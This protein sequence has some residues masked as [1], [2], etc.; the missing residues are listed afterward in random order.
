MLRKLT[1]A[2]FALI[3]FLP[4]SCRN[5]DIIPKDIMSQIYYDMYINDQSVKSKYI[6]R[7]MSDT[8]HVYAPIF[9]KYGY[10]V[11]DYQK[12]VNHYLLDPE[13]FEDIFKETVTLLE[14]KKALL[15]ALIA[16]EE[17]RSIRW[18]FLDSLE[19]FT[20]D[21]I[22]SSR[23]YRT[24]RILFFQAD[25]IVPNSPV[26]D[27]AF[28]DRPRSRFEIFSDSVL[29]SDK[30]FKFYKTLGIFPAL[31]HKDT[32]D[33]L[34]TD[35]L[36]LEIE[37]ISTKESIKEPKG[38]VDP[39]TL[40]EPQNRR[41]PKDIRKGPEPVQ[42]TLKGNRSSSDSKGKKSSTERRKTMKER[43]FKIDSTSKKPTKPGNTNKPT[44]PNKPIKPT[45]KA[46]STKVK[47]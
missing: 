8:L 36:E 13:E 28:M 45:Q 32:L 39:K 3:C 18:E 41:D 11:E 40:K 35:S 26:I 27:S 19:Y 9:E 33:T 29:N 47:K 1:I 22:Q 20:A 10:S 14:K 7:R 30:D 21:T 37:P 25:T 42:T 15:E 44:K 12:S 5:R 17:K 43:Q 31:P 4:Q 24:L 16:A 46:D 2:I 38:K 23:Y 34:Q 6:F